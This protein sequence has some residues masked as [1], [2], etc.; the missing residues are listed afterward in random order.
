MPSY[1]IT[2]RTQNHYEQPVES[3]AFE[4]LVLP[5]E[6]ETQRLE[7][8]RLQHQPRQGRHFSAR[9]KYDFQTIH[10]HYHKPFS[11]LNL[12]LSALLEKTPT[13]LKIF[14]TEGFEREMA[15]LHDPEFQIN[16]RSFLQ[17]TPLTQVYLA[18]I[19]AHFLQQSEEP[20]GVYALRLCKVLR[21]F[22]SYQVGA[23]NTESTAREVLHGKKGVCQ[24]YTHLM[25]AI[26]RAQNL[27]ARYVSG[28]LKGV[29]DA[30][31]QLHAWVEAYL[32]FLGW[33]GFDPTN[34]LQ[35][36]EN[37][38]KIAHGR[39]YLDCQSIKGVLGPTGGTHETHYEV[40]VGDGDLYPR[41]VQDQQQQ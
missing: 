39:D 27:A 1:Y 8:W 21:H 40:L 11:Q 22:L 35:E 9:N 15:Y 32:P 10:L 41:Q 23:T 38:V 33:R 29:D 12:E 3:G 17:F 19:P 26:L 31:A 5:C 37:Y 20:P 4:F 30:A 2:Y 6:N 24:D 16:H 14:S 13:D 25:L 34:E 18:E 28:Y 7:D 36:D